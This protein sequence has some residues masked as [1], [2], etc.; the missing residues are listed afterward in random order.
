MTITSIEQR[1]IN[2]I[3]EIIHE[4]NAYPA[5]CGTPEKRLSCGSRPWY[6]ALIFTAAA[7][8]W[9]FYLFVIY[10]AAYSF[11]V[12]ITAFTGSGVE[13]LRTFTIFVILCTATLF[14]GRT[15]KK[16]CCYAFTPPYMLLYLIM[17]FAMD[18]FLICVLGLWG[19]LATVPLII[20]LLAIFY[21]LA[22]K[23]WFDRMV[24]TYT[25]IEG[26]SDEEIEEQIREKEEMAKYIE[27]VAAQHKEL[28]AKRRAQ[29]A[30]EYEG[31]ED[32]YYD[33]E[34]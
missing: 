17:L 23:R 27:E 32:E 25:K 2:R 1:T 22:Y 21:H 16:A 26:M 34:F 5:L 7:A 18:V 29:E 8:S 24:E 15:V 6:N 4:C 31:E 19:M 28:L 13:I 33:E 14:L 12:F 3:Q 9:N 20:T 11:W 10:F 30:K